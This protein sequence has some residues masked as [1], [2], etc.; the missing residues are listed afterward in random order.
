M[1]L[2]AVQEGGF[3]LE[4]SIEVERIAP[5]H[6]VDVDVRPL[7][8]V[9]SGVRIERA[10]AC[11]EL[12]QFVRCHQIGL[13]DQDDIRERDLVLGLGRVLEPIRQPLGIRYGDDG[14][15]FRLRADGLVHEEGLRDG[16]RIRQAGGFDDDGVEFALAAHQAVNDPHQIAAHG[17][18]DAAIVHFEYFLIGVHDEVVVNADLAEF[19][20]DDRE[21]LAVRFRQDTVEQRGFAG[22]EI[23]GQYGDGN[24]GG[25]L[26]GEHQT[27]DLRG[28]GDIGNLD[29]KYKGP[30][31]L[32]RVGRAPGAGIVTRPQP[33]L[34]SITVVMLGISSPGRVNAGGTRKVP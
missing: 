8:P 9:Q 7:G 15:K 22:S 29:R 1:M 12:T 10:N 6:L 25:G 11:L 34:A 30:R 23:A 20:D 21:F 14:I 18:A 27:L 24:F 4:D 3:D 5:E 16:R 26:R 31:V 32:D 13:V 19:I 17:A 33:W 2:D 28:R